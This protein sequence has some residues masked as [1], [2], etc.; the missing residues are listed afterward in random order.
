MQ[1]IY[2][3]EATFYE[4]RMEEFLDVAKSLEIKQL[5]ITEPDDEPGIYP[6]TSDQETPT[7]FVDEKT[8]NQH[9]TSCVVRFNS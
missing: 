6:S 7:K 2:L 3:G 8:I 1:F 9:Y 5:Y 4:E